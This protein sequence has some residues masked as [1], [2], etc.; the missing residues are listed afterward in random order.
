[1]FG[2]GMGE[3]LVILAVALLVLGPKRL[4]EMASGLGKAIRDFRRATQDIQSQL[5]VD[6]TVAKPF[7]ELKSALRDQPM[8]LHVKPLPAARVPEGEVIASVAPSASGSAAAAVVAATPVLAVESPAAPEG[9][10]PLDS[11]PAAKA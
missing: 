11:A 3:L 9:G 7:A 1:M 2:L 5:E 10:F 8:P 6:E 4:P